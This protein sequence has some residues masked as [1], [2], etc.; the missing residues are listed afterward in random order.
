VDDPLLLG[1]KGKYLGKILYD[2]D[3]KNMAFGG[4]K[5]TQ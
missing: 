5:K 4:R 1:L 2:N 3:G